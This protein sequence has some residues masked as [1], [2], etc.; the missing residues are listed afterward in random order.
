MKIG[1]LKPEIKTIDSG[2]FTFNKH[3]IQKDVHYTVLSKSSGVKKFPVILQHPVHKHI[4]LV[5][6]SGIDFLGVS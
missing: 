4:L 2:E 6:P 1:R 5:V 3:H